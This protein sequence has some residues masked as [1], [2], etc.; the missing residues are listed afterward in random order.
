VV[1]SELGAFRGNFKEAVGKLRTLLGL[2]EGEDLGFMYDKPIGPLKGS[3]HT[4]LVCV[5]MCDVSV[6]DE[7]YGF[8]F[9]GAWVE[10]EAF[11]NPHYKAFCGVDTVAEPVHPPKKGEEYDPFA[12]NP[13]GFRWFKGV[14]L[15]TAA[16]SRI[17]DKGVYLAVFKVCSTPTGFKIMVNEHNRI[18]IPIIFLTETQLEP[19]EVKWM[20]GVRMRESFGIDVL[21]GAKPNAGWLGPEM[22]G[23]DGATFKEKLHWAIGE[24]KARFGIDDKKPLGAYYDQELLQV[25]EMNNMQILLYGSLATSDDDI[26]PG[27]IWVEREALEVQNMKYY[28]PTMH[29]ASLQEQQKLIESYHG[30]DDGTLKTP[31]ET[32][33]LRMD[34]D[35]IKDK[36]DQA[37]E[38]QSPLKWV[39]R[40]IM[41]CAD[42]MPSFGEAFLSDASTTPAGEKAA[43]A[44]VAIE[45]AIAH[46]TMTDA[47]NYRRKVLIKKYVQ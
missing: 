5:K 19:A 37:I 28:C 12:P 38:Q 31:E 2:K 8:G 43:V 4:L 21:E 27:H 17:P 30:L 36:L 7:P 47:S 41:W 35:A 39:N 29:K 46:N 16:V 11:E 34:R 42:K 33:K 25:D 22:S 24:A 9:K 26:L 1:P 10:H 45:K 14:T 44:G 23:E 15:F 20:H 40:V 32:A 3:R 18:M 6:H 13:A